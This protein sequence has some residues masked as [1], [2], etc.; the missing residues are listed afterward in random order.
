[1]LPAHQNPFAMERIARKLP[2]DPAWCGTSWDEIIDRLEHRRWRGQIVGP[3]G[4][5]KTTFLD[6]LVPRLE[7]RGFSVARLFLS[8]ENPRL[9]RDTGKTLAAQDPAAFCLIDGAEQLGLLSRR[10]F[11]RRANQACAGLVLTTHRPLSGPVPP[12]LELRTSPEMLATFIRRLAPEW[13][14]RISPSEIEALHHASG[15]NV[16]EALWRCYDR[17]SAE[18]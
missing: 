3:H 6:A 1:M 5:G 9:P 10:R 15:G 11:L 18:S 13:S 12:L 14:D 16:R 8:R 17:L 2:F 4:S 7:A